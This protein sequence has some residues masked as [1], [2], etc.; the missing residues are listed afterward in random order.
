MARHSMELIAD[1]IWSGVCASDGLARIAARR[2]EAAVRTYIFMI[3]IPR[4]VV[5][6]EYSL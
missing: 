1:W 6:V 2:R 5:M 3:G 4:L